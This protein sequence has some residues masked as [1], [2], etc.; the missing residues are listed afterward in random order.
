M[1]ETVLLDIEHEVNYVP[2]TTGQRFANYIVDFVAFVMVY[3]IIAIFF[4]LPNDPVNVEAEGDTILDYLLV[5]ILLVLYYTIL[6]G[7]TKG[8]TLGKLITGT[9]A[10]R[11][12]GEKITWKDAML[13]SLTRIVPFEHLSALG[14]VPW[15]D[16]WTKTRVYKLRKQGL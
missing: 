16:T 11:E 4:L 8:R 3:V 6:E 10:L 5:C 14:G 1:H 13:R 15:H 2:A 9:I 12:D 7:L